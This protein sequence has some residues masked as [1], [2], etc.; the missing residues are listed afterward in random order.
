MKYMP[1]F[2]VRFSQGSDSS[3]QELVA[4][5]H[6]HLGLDAV[7]QLFWT[8]LSPRLL[9]FLRVAMSVYV[10]DRLGRR[11]QQSQERRWFRSLRLSVA[12]QE[13]EFWESDEVF[14]TLMECLD[15]LSEDAW[16][17]KFVQDRREQP[18]H[19]ARFLSGDNPFAAVPPLVCLYSGGLD[20]AAGLGIRIAENPDRP[21][22][23]VTVWHQ[24]NQRETVHRQLDALRERYGTSIH[25]LIVKGAMVWSSDLKGWKPERSQRC[26]SFLF[27][28]VGAVAAAI[29]EV[30]KVEVFESG[31]GAINLPLLAGMVGSRATRGS[32]PHFFR[33]MSRLSSLV[34]G[35]EVAFHLPFI[36]KTK[37]QV[38]RQ[39][40]RCGL[41][42]LARSTISCVHYPLR[43][44]PHK[45][46]GVC[47]AC[48]FRR[49]A[50]L[51]AGIKESRDTYKYDLFGPVRR[52]N[53]IREKRLDYLKAFLLQVANLGPL[54]PGDPVPE[55][56][57]RHLLG[58]NVVSPGE[59]LDPFLHLFARYRH[60]WL[61][62]AAK[63]MERG[64]TWANLMAPVGAAL[65]GRENHASA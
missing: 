32:H 38:V 45:Q 10:A 31:I 21:V 24:P 65:I 54:E 50:M 35:R 14:A 36:D 62:I 15:F 42:D 29:S 7:E 19:V 27:A 43:E 56:I 23:P 57:R 5:K 17:L 12:V 25:P 44:R 33:L 59:C 3:C 1:P 48:L 20:S 64:W 63:G 55:R 9:D 61:S 28:A 30:T 22:I 51:V 40:G 13:P 49:Q 37:G 60:E 58:T 16:D 39:M 4:G 52:A 2:T 11:K 53:R 47:P 26:R 18:P 6:F 41:K 46:C 8:N 34:A